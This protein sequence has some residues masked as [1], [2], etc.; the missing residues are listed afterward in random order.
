MKYTLN[1]FQQS[2]FIDRLVAFPCENNKNVKAKKR[3]PYNQGVF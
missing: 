2:T 1:E 3:M